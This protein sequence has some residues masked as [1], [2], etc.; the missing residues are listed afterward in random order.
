MV[1]ALMLKSD[2]TPPLHRSFVTA[3]HPVAVLRRLSEQNKELRAELRSIN[4]QLDDLIQSAAEKHGPMDTTQG[5]L[6]T[7]SKVLPVYE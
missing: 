6:K 7:A 3:A 5:E 4:G 1:T 2:H